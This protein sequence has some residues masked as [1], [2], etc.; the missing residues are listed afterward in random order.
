MRVDGGGDGTVGAGGLYQH[1]LCPREI[2]EDVLERGPC[3]G[4]VAEARKHE[5]EV[6]GGGGG[7]QVREGHVTSITVLAAPHA[8]LV[9]QLVAR[10]GRLACI[11]LP[12]GH[13]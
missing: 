12:A 1:A 6:A 13:S 4:V 9:H 10:K 2:D 3:L 5:L 8:V 11:Q 7:G